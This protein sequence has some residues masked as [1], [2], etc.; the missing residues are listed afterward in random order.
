MTLKPGLRVIEC[1]W[2]WQHSIDRIVAYKFLF[3]FHCDY[4]RILYRFRNRARYWRFI[5]LCKN[6]TCTIS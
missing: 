4:G 2:K 3:V 5:S 1:H 6:W